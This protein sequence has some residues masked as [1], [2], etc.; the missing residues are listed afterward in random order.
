MAHFA[1]LDTNNTVLRVISVNNSEL[2][3]AQGNESEDK[4]VA[5]CT[6]LLGGRWI[7][8]S[9][10]GSFRVRFAST[11]FVYNEYHDAFIAPQPYASWVF[12]DNTLDWLPPIPYPEDGN[13]YL[14][15][16]NT[17]SWILI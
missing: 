5:F 17:V 7:Q 13:Q 3:D 15:D 8:T 6:S 14:W 1:E 9:Y 16:E 10:N 4:G 12:S 11:G 2:I